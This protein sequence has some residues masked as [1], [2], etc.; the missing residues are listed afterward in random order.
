MPFLEELPEAAKKPAQVQVFLHSM[1]GKMPMAQGE[2]EY[3]KVGRGKAPG[4]M[5]VVEITGIL[6]PAQLASIRSFF[7]KRAEEFLQQKE[8]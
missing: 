1:G 8:K 7:V 5:S 4:K 2:G 6:S 3:K